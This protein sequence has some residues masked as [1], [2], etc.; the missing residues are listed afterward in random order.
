MRSQFEA[1]HGPTA[2]TDQALGHTALNGEVERPA[3]GVT[4]LQ[5]QFEDI[6]HTVWVAEADWRLNDRI[7]MAT[8]TPGRQ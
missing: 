2:N 3:A 1:N 5:T 7:D 8:K 4:D 6:L